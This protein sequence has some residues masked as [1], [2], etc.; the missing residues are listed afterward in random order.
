V[1]AEAARREDVVLISALTGS[2]V[3]DLLE[4]AAGHLRKGTQLRTVT[5]GASDGEA[6]AWLHANGE[7][8][9]EQRGE[10]ETEFEVRLSAA[11]WA[12][13]EARRERG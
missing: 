12:R 13:F 5:L 9:R 7:I 1:N 3:D 10:L 11:A 6:I 4:C 8:V 2:G